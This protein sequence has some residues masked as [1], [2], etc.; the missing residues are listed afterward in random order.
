MGGV[1]SWV[2]SLG[3]ED[4]A[5]LTARE[6]SMPRSNNTP[7]HLYIILDLKTEDMVFV[8]F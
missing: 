7:S 5:T 2:V 4:P 6:D 1:A 8:L 3:G